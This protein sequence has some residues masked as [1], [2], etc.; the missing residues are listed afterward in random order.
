MSLSQLLNHFDEKLSA[1]HKSTA[2]VTATSFYMSKHLFRVIDFIQ[3]SGFKVSYVSVNDI[4]SESENSNDKV[5]LP[6]NIERPQ[7]TGIF[8]LNGMQFSAKKIS[9]NSKIGQLVSDFDWT[10]RFPE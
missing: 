10:L 5:A 4:V 3:K 8:M 1:N 7:D 2:I 9:V 6:Q